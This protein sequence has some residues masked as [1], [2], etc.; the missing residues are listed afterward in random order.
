MREVITTDE[1]QETRVKNQETKVLRS[2]STAHPRAGSGDFAL[3][4]F[5]EAFSAPCLDPDTRR[6]CEVKR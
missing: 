2:F 3:L 1:N 4:F 6:L 5:H